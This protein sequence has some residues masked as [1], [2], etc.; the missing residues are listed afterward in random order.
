M[1][2]YTS[3]HGPLAVSPVCILKSSGPYGSLALPYLDGMMPAMRCL[4]PRRSTQRHSC[5]NPKHLVLRVP[6][7]VKYVRARRKA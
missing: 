5:P 3:F 7:P 2:E 1:P 4:G 6:S